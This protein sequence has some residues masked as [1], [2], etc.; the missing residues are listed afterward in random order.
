ME[1]QLDQLQHAANQGGSTA[2]LVIAQ[3]QLSRLGGL[4]QTIEHARGVNLVSI[5]AEVTAVVAATLATVQQARAA[6]AG[7]Q[8]AE[9]ALHEAQ[10]EA[11]RTTGDFLRDFY[12]RRIFD[13]YLNFT[14]TEDERAYREREE[15]R[16]KEIEKARAEGTPEGE[17]R[18]IELQQAQLKDAGAHG[19]T[20]SPD[21][22]RWTNRLEAAKSNLKAAMAP[23]VT[24]ER[25]PQPE[26]DPL[27]SIAP[28]ATVDPEVLAALRAS[29]VTL[30]DPSQQGHGVAARQAATSQGMARV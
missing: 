1:A 28:S 13:K 19:A 11:H 5:R 9:L 6:A 15:A 17:L 20:D 23:T 7:G 12:E 14:S 26:T 21:Y 18:A 24:H 22:Q 27:D 10:A 16:Q 8:A 30:A 29:G 25:S 4:G 2:A 3:N